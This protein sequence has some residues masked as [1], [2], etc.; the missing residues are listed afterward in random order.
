[1][2]G[3]RALRGP[4]ASTPVVKVRIVRRLLTLLLVLAALLGPAG[5]GLFADEEDERLQQMLDAN[6]TF[7][8]FLRP[9]VTPQQKT[10]VDAYLRDLPEVAEVKYE[11][12]EEAYRRFK[13]LWAD[14]PEFAQKVSPDSLPGSFRVRMADNAAIRK[15]RD[16][17]GEA[18]IKN[19]PGV[20]DV[21]LGC[22]TVGECKEIARKNGR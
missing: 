7:S 2:R 16:G 10:N 18:N 13:E 4:H 12:R 11:T 6:P 19:L 22:V 9:D 14:N 5:C 17:S 8:V 3:A 20:Q 21:V 15:V 1:M